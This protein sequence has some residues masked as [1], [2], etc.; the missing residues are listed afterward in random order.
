VAGL[1]LV[2]AV[3]SN[4]LTRAWDWIDK[5]G[6]IRRVVL[7]LAIWMTWKVSVWGMHYAS[8]TTLPGLD[9]AAV[10]AA[11]TAPITLFAGAVFKAYVESRP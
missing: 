7:G 4:A 10:I 1:V 2:A 5:R 6:I 8:I 3:I 9:A 11:V